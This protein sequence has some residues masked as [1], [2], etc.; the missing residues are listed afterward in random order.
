[1][2]FS[3]LRRQ[4]IFALGAVA[5]AACGGGTST[6]APA[7]GDLVDMTMGPEDAP[8]VLVEYAS[9]VCGACAYFHSTM[10][11][12]IKELAGEGKLRFVFREY[13]TSDVDVAGFSIARCAGDDK[14]FD[15]LD[16]LFVNQRGLLQAARNN[17]IRTSFAAIAARHGLDTAE[18]EACLS[19]KSVQEN[20]ANAGKYANTIGVSATPTLFLNNVELVQAEGRSPESLIELIEAAQ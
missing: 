13:A 19:N 5:L 8:F 17:T 2:T 10:G 7:E 11:D 16:D 4:F 15:V 12:T 18:F 1:M 3:K 9:S 14:Y 6:D 20:I